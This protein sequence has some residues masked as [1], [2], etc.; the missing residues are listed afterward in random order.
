MFSIWY[1]ETSNFT[2]NVLLKDFFGLSLWFHC[3]SE[4]EDAVLPSCLVPLQS[5]ALLWLDRELSATAILLLMCCVNISAGP[6]GLGS[7]P[8]FS[9]FSVA[10]LP[11]ALCGS[12]RRAEC[13]IM[14]Q[15]ELS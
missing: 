15:C 2:F 3:P 8:Y 1:D 12:L 5:L 14:P 13:G 4:L 9:V 10:V 11:T 6:G 7:L